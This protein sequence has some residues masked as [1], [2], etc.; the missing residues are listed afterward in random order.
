VSV[1]N[2]EPRRLLWNKQLPKIPQEAFF[3][4]E[5]VEAL[6]METEVVPDGIQL[7]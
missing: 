2:P 7:T 6:P 4:S 5:K 3:V 1:W